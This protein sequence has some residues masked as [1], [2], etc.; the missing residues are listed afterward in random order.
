MKIMTI[1]CLIG[2]GEGFTI[3]HINCTY[4]TGGSYG[5]EGGSED[6]THDPPLSAGQFNRPNNF[7]SN[8]AKGSNY[9]HLYA[10]N[11]IHMS[12]K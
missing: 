9:G 4:G 11:R 10:G 1:L 2:P 6:S 12:R 7:G 8:G 5:G 3:E